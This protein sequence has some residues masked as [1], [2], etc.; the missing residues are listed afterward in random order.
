MTRIASLFLAASFLSSCTAGMSSPQPRS[1]RAENELH[2]ALD[3]KVAGRPID[4][5]Q[6]RTSG[7]MQIIDDNTIL[8][9]EGRR[10]YVQ[11]PRG[12]C[13]PLGS[14]TYTLVTHSYGGMGLCRG[15]IVRVFDLQGGF[16]V[17]SCSLNEFVPFE[18]PGRS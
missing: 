5:L 10:I 4:C 13:A 7:D 17:G 15:D 9:R 2:R 1:L 3:G 18:R 11:A 6:S 8:F 12:G 16:E 14:G